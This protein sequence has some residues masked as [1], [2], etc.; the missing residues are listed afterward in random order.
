MVR[1]L[2]EGTLAAQ[3]PD[4]GFST[5]ESLQ[6]SVKVAEALNF[7]PEKVQNSY[8]AIESLNRKLTETVGFS[9]DFNTS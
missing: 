9:L 1:N 7:P 8:N 2:E 5:L 4:A 3:N 6:E